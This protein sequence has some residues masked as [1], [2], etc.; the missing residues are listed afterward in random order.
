MWCRAKRPG[1][2]AN[3]HV[4]RIHQPLLVRIHDRPNTPR[5]SATG[6]CTSPNARGNEVHEQN[7]KLFTSIKICRTLKVTVNIALLDSHA[8]LRFGKQ[9]TCSEILPVSSASAAAAVRA[10]QRCTHGRMQQHNCLHRREQECERVQYSDL[11]ISG[12]LDAQQWQAS[13]QHRNS[14]SLQCKQR[15]RTQPLHDPGQ[16]SGDKI[17]QQHWKE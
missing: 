7:P 12:R 4:S 8:I 16:N 3:V 1:D 11:L 10:K 9:C 5:K 15:S 17:C 6:T 2:G 13:D 14:S